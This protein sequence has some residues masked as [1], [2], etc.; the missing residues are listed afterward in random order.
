MK[1][2]YFSDIHLEFGDLEAPQ[3]AADIIVAAGDIGPGLQGIEWLR[4]LSKPVVYIAGNHEFYGQE[5]QHNLQAIRAACVDTNVHFLDNEVLELSGVRF[6]GCTLWT[7]LHAEGEERLRKVSEILNDFRRIQYLDLSFTA[8][9]FSDLH[10]HSC[11]WLEKELAKPFAG[12]TVVVT[13]H[14]PTYWSWNKDQGAVKR[15][16][17]CN[18]LKSLL[19]EN[20]VDAWF[21]GH[22][23]SVSDYRV[24]GA[25]IL[26]NP[27]GYAGS[28]L[29]AGFDLNRMVDI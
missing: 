13:H 10:R 4:C 12:K 14:A 22:I 24:A 8:E 1:I 25:R 9:H 29:V 28:K 27:R 11:R 19:H 15:L 21:H 5:M 23:H 18:D 20:P 7:D 6:L 16:A 3:N 17:Y 26:C 2:N